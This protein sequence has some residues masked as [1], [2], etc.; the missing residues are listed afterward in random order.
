MV[1]QSKTIIGADIGSPSDYSLQLN[2]W[3][4]KPIGAWPASPSTTKLERVVSV[5]LI[6]VCYG[7]ILF[8]VI[9]WILHI[10]LEET[11][12]YQKLK[13]IG[14]LIHWVMGGVKLA[15]LLASSNE[16][17]HCVKHL[18][19]DWQI[20]SGIHRRQV[21]LRYAKL[22]RY[23]SVFCAAFMQGGVFSYCLIATMST[24]SVEI[25]NDTRTIHMLPFVFYQKLIDTD[26]SPANEIII[27]SQFLSAFVANSI[28]VGGFSLAAVF[29]AHA[30]G[31]LNILMSRITELV[32][33]FRGRDT[34][35][36]FEDIGLVVQY[37]IRIL[38]F[39]SRIEDVISPICFSELFHNSLSTCLIGYYI[40]MEWDE[41][42]YRNLTTYLMIM[43]SM[44][45]NIFLLCYIGEVLTDQCS[46]VGYVVYMTEWYCL[47]YKCVLDL[48]MIIA[49]SSVVMKITANK[50]V[51]MSICTFSQVV[52]S[53]FAYLNLL[54]ETT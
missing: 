3:Y 34:K 42:D 50:M 12:L 16:I 45:F 37:H 41:R 13:T 11:E 46:K 20:V 31:Q 5:L 18:E 8:T 21:M 33:E 54:R 51:H 10:C 2:R 23:V 27:A 19:A 43:F 14:P 26:Q 44:F 15:I 36:F 53:S 17:R 24:K 1:N 9:P 47:P 40:L 39:I 49:R 52:K 22:G 30:C 28:A 48:R 32:N 29:A 38:N 35:I 6:I 4:L 25:G 7:S